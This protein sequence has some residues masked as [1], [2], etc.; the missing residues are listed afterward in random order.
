M[1][2]DDLVKKTYHQFNTNPKSLKFYLPSQLRV[3]TTSGDVIGT[4]FNVSGGKV[5]TANVVAAEDFTDCVQFYL[6]LRAYFQH[7]VV[8]INRHTGVVRW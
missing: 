6:A 2:S 4:T 7:I 3:S 5:T 1:L 8:H